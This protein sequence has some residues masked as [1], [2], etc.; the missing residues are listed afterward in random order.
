MKV[1]K[2]TGGCF[3]FCAS[4]RN[5]NESYTH[6]LYPHINYIM[7]NPSSSLVGM[8]QGQAK[9]NNNNN[10]T[11]NN[12]NENNRLSSAWSSMTCVKCEQNSDT[13]ET[14]LDSAIPPSSPP[15]PFPNFTSTGTGDGDGGV[16]DLLVHSTLEVEGRAVR[17]YFTRTEVYWTTWNGDRCKF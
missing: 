3:K 17:G 12:N 16:G 14:K 9:F 5:N 6:I 15:P 8:T 10:H 2:K 1:C 7:I 4:L 11:D 13:Y